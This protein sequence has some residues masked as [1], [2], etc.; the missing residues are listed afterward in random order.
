MADRI[1]SVCIINCFDTYE[2]R[3][4]LLHD[5]FKSIGAKV[6]VIT[7]DYRHFEKCRRT[8]YKE[9]FEF[10]DSAFDL[11][12]NEYRDNYRVE[13]LKKSIELAEGQSRTKRVLILAS[14][15]SMID[16]FNVPNIR[17]LQK[18]GYSVDVACNFLQGNSCSVEQIAKLKI[19]LEEMG[20]RY[21]QI[22]FSRSVFRFDKNYQ[23]YRQV[24]NLMKNNQ[25]S[26][27][28]CHSPIGGVIGRIAAHNTKTHVIYTAHGFHFF[29]GAPKKNWI[30]F[31]P[32]EKVLS[33][34]T[35][36]LIT[37]NSEDYN[38]AAKKFSS[39][40]I[41]KI[42]GVGIDVEKFHNALGDP[43]LKNKLGISQ[44]DFVLISVGEL[45]DNKNHRAIIEAIHILNDS[46][47]KYLIIGMGALKESLQ[48]LVAEYKLEN[49]VFFLGFRDDVA[50]LLKIADVFCFPSKREGLGLAAVEAMASGLPLITSNVHGINDYSVNGK[51]GYS[52][53]PNDYF[54]FAKSIRELMLNEDK[55][56]EFGIY[57]EKMSEK[58]SVKKVDL[59]MRQIYSEIGDL[60]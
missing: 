37:I 42:P 25:Y 30:I 52:C 5:Y 18:L 20:V 51:T 14:V 53:S 48:K 21:Y 26:F 3:V 9:D 57:N 44:N 8:D 16:Q 11:K 29:K 59:L 27:V 13:S 12:I 39:N 58:Y 28:H 2:H 22:D 41:V 45:N 33:R 55:R 7:S 47:I 40:K 17:L 56:K 1:N 49:Q 35:D 50:Q 4:D 36:Y 31:Y 6:R 38:L 23:A 19:L 15:A 43:T 10:G 46:Q 60:L 34:I 24:K 32:I 54:A